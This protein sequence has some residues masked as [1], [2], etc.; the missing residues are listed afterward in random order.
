MQEKANYKNK[1]FSVLGDSI[2][3]LSGV[4]LPDNASFYV[5]DKQFETGVFTM[6]DT[7]WGQV[8]SRF[9][10]ELLVNNS[11]SGSTVIKHPLYEIPS[12]GC[13]DE[14]TSAL[15]KEGQKPDVIMVF[16]GINDWGNGVQVLPQNENEKGDLS[17]FSVAYCE[18]LKKLRKN[19]P[20]AESWC[21]TLPISTCTK[22][23]T[24]R[25]PY[26]Y[27]GTHVGEYCAA[28]HTCAKEYDCRV[29]DLFGYGIPYDTIDGF[30]PNKTGMKT[31]A[32]A[33]ISK[34]F[35]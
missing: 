2:S 13:S 19:Y 29:I 11:I 21:F 9:G 31:L 6:L 18:M 1:Y 15:S 12:Y 25:Y 30:H 14:R 32:D 16:L 7:W 26:R 22:K 17:I 35:E 4:S 23:E 34:L 5:G 27:G 8:I 10:G 24:F 33:V 28:I 20:K 3:T